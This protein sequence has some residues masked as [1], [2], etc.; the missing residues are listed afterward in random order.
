MN[1]G[2]YHVNR[3]IFIAFIK[4]GETKEAYSFLERVYE[5]FPNIYWVNYALA[6]NAINSKRISAAEKYLA[7]AL[8]AFMGGMNKQ[9][10]FSFEKTIEGK[11]F[12]LFYMITQNEYHVL[13]D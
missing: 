5:G 12:S 10:K 4:T 1:Q 9:F 13:F 7:S 6:M 3:A 2:H 8:E 11:D